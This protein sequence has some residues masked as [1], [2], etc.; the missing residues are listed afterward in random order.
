MPMAVTGKAD[1][2]TRPTERFVVGLCW[3]AMGHQVG[4]SPAAVRDH[5]DT[6]RA[7]SRASRRL[8]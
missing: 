5:A 7:G 4:S 1:F 6:Q 8:T 3:L 2:A